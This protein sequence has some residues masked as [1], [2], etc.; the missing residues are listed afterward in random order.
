M[1]ICLIGN[2]NKQTDNK[3]REKL[4]TMLIILIIVKTIDLKLYK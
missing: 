3:I 1:K 4:K 2:T